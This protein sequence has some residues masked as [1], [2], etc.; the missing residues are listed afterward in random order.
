SSDLPNSV[1][2][3]STGTSTAEVTF[4][5][6]LT[7]RRASGKIASAP[8]STYALARSI[9]AS[10]PCRLRTSVR[11]M[12]RKFSS[13]RAAAAARI[14]RTAS[15]ASTTCLPSRCPQRFGFTWSS[16]WQPARPASSSIWMVRAAFIG[17][18]KPVSA[19]TIVGRSL[20]RAICPARVATSVSVVSPM[21]G[22]PR[23]AASTAPETYT[24]SKPCSAISR[25]DSGFIA[26]GNR[27]SSPVAS[28]SRSWRRLAAAEVVACSIST[29]PSRSGQPRGR[30][31]PEP[32]PR[33]Q[34]TPEP[35][36][37]V[38]DTL[39]PCP[40]V[41][42]APEPCPRVQD[43]PEPCPRVQDAPEPCPRVR[44]APEPCPRVRGASEQPLRAGHP[45]EQARRG[46]DRQTEQLV[47]GQLAGPG[48]HLEEARDLIRLSDAVGQGMELRHVL[49]PRERTG[50]ERV[51]IGHRDLL[52]ERAPVGQGDLHPTT[53]RLLRRV[54]GVVA[55]GPG[56]IL[57]GGD[58]APQL[59]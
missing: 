21:S 12:T 24:P 50:T 28:A 4:S 17:S 42:D 59:H 2:F 16:M 15:A 53:E 43:A 9:V 48:D 32:C 27:S 20:I 25:A 33:V 19:S 41:Q 51:R 13:R 18:P 39:E 26:P 54:F 6:S 7:S 14:R 22:S 1:M 8:A 3:A 44:G 11:A 10:R 30:R 49:L 23:S 36:P 31:A 38:Q 34:D 46:G 47:R 57:G 52:A 5:S 35:C 58:L 40:R 29:S 37:R 56:R 55:A 45:A